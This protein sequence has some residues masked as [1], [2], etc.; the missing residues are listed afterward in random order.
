MS[1]RK[2]HYPLLPGWLQHY[3]ALRA[4]DFQAFSDL[5]MRLSD[6]GNTAMDVWITGRYFLLA[7]NY[8][9]LGYPAY[10]PGLP[11]TGIVP[12]REGALTAM[13]DQVFYP[14]IYA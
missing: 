4:L 6:G 13:L 3:A 12:L 5:H 14:E 1:R 7:S 10:T 2:K 11:R 8:A 9:A